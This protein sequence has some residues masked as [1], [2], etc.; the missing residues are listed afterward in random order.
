MDF[1]NVPVSLRCAHCGIAPP[2]AIDRF[3][4]CGKCKMS[5]YCSVACQRADWSGKHKPICTEAIALLEESSVTIAVGDAAIVA[6]CD[7]MDEGHRQVLAAI[8]TDKCGEPN[9]TNQLTTNE[10]HIYALLDCPIK[11]TVH[12]LMLNFCSAACR[13][14]T[15]ILINLHTQ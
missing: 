6:M 14:S 12:P 3:S 13:A 15:A 11:H 8:R 7:C 2:T 4:V 9:C 1:V 10:H 5:R